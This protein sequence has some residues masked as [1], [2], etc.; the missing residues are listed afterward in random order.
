MTRVNQYS[1]CPECG[2]K[3]FSMI[4]GNADCQECG[5]RV[6]ETPNATI[7]RLI[8]RVAEL[9]GDI[10]RLRRLV[11]KAI[12]AIDEPYHEATSILNA[13]L[14]DNEGG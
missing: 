11:G 6:Y 1:G 3:S 5:H 10:C 13:A 4:G 2:G 8:C 9:E 7:Y 14:S 12:D